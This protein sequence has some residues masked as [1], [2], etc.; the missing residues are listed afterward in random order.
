MIQQSSLLACSSRLNQVSLELYNT[1]GAALSLFGNKAC[2]MVF[3]PREDSILFSFGQFFWRRTRLWALSSFSTCQFTML[4][5]N[6]LLA[7]RT[8]FGGQIMINSVVIE[9]LM[10]NDL[11]SFRFILGTQS[12]FNLISVLSRMS[13]LVYLRQ[14]RRGSDR[15]IHY[16]VFLLSF[17]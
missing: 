14:N 3:S 10:L 6:K 17:I 2:L 8:S 12:F 4:C 15:I 5:L 11:H 1:L 9:I 7:L 16:S 13:S